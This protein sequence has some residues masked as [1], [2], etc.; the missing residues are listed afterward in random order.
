MPLWAQL[1]LKSSVPQLFVKNIFLTTSTQTLKLE[2][3]GESSADMKIPI[4]ETT[5][6][7]IHIMSWDN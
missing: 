3:A 6:V 5:N 2:I 1:R 7:E 4:S